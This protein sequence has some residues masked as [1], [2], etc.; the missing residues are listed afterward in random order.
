MNTFEVLFSLLDRRIDPKKMALIEVGVPKMTR[1][2]WSWGYWAG[3]F[4]S[5]SCDT[6]DD[7]F[8]F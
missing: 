1:S 3:F 5:F 8:S 7:D 4:M 6:W 2:T